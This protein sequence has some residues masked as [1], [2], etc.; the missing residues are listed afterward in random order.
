MKRNI[1][2]QEPSQTGLNLVPFNPGL[3]SHGPSGH[4]ESHVNTPN[5]PIGT[6]LSLRRIGLFQF[7][8]ESYVERRNRD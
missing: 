5:S 3:C 1:K 2:E 4:R 8:S 7:N 6:P